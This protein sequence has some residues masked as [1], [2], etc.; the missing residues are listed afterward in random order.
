MQFPKEKTIPQY[1]QLRSI[2]CP[3]TNTLLSYYTALFLYWDRGTYGGLAVLSGGLNL[4]IHFSW[5]PS[6]LEHYVKQG[7]NRPWLELL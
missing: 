4:N 6:V 1:G 3:N 5:L 2:I 7:N